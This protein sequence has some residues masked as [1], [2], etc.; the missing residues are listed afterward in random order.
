M[1]WTLL[2]IAGLLEIVWAI[3]IKYTQGFTRLVPTV[4]TVVSTV[5]SFYLL[6]LALKQIPVGTG[7]AVWVGIGAAGTAV[8]GMFFLGEPKTA[9]RIGSLCLIVLGILGLKLAEPS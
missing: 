2:V 9:L 6:S 8:I 4:V 1:H 7:Y 3:A 5:V